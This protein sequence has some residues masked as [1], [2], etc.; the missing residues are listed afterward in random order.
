MD[1]V[2]SD[3]EVEIIQMGGK[4]NYW[5]ESSSVSAFVMSTVGPLF[6]LSIWLKD[7]YFLK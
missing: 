1:M 5:S 2:I 7:G 6:T 4:S 3:S